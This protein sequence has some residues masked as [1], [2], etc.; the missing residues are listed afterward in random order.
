MTYDL[1]GDEGTFTCWNYWDDEADDVIPL[2]WVNDGTV[3]CLFHDDELVDASDNWFGLEIDEEEDILVYTGDCQV[4]GEDYGWPW[5]FV[6]D[7]VEDCDGATDEDD[8]TGTMTYTC[9]DGTEISFALLNDGSD[10][11]ADGEDEPIV[12]I[13]EYTC[14]DGDRALRLRQ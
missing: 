10:D 3:D 2:S 8:G 7:G 1:N 4:D 6:N 13:S 9:D 11:C 14:G 5:V 12:I